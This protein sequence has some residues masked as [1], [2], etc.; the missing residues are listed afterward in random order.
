VSDGVKRALRHPAAHLI[1]ISLVLGLEYLAVRRLIGARSLAPELQATM[2]A[3]DA[4]WRSGTFPRSAAY[5][6]LI[7]AILIGVRALG[8]P[9]LDPWLFNLATA[10]AGMLAL[11]GL[12][13]RALG[14][15]LPALAA[16]LL[17]LANP[18]ALWTFLLSRDAGSEFLFGGL[19]LWAAISAAKREVEGKPALGVMLLALLAGIALGLTRVTGFFI[20]IAVFLIAF[21]ISRT[22]RQRRSWAFALAG[23]VASA[24][25]L[26]AFNWRQVGAFRL[27]TNGGYNLYLGNHPAYLHAHPHYDVDVFLGAVAQAEGLDGLPEAE[28]DSAYT[29]RALE[30]IRADPAAFGLRLVLKSVWHW[31]NLEKVPNYTSPSLLSADGQT[32]H[33]AAIDVLPSLA[34]VLYKLIY[35][36]LLLLAML[37][38]F[39]GRIESRMWLL[40]GPL[41][42]LWPVLALTFPD[43]RFKI[44]AELLAWPAMVVAWL[45]LRRGR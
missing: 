34:Y 6:P 11:Y 22:A 39:L 2:D 40:F 23:V 9:P 16:A 36:P 28:R 20:A 33:L 42:G 30:F 7:P 21:L 38:L 26:C 25:L 8:L 37:L 4:A 15:A 24:L 44:D 13:R 29:R 45:W 35:L 18:Y 1:L 31:F 5:P 17:A 12:A 32:A 41:L 43:T 27:A 14:A 3:V 19:M 10:W